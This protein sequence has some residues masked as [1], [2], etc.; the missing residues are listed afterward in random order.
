MTATLHLQGK[1]GVELLHDPLLNKGTAFTESERDALGLRGLLPPRVANQDQQLERVLENF[2][3]KTSDLEKYIYLI[4]LQERNEALFYRLVTQN[5]EEMMPI[6]YTPTVGLACQKYGHIF[7]RPR[8]LYITRKDRGRIRS[9]LQ[10]W[11]QYDVRIIVVTDGERILGLGDLGANGMGIPVGKLSLYTA[12]AGI[13]PAQTLPIMFDVGTNNPTLLADP[14]YLGLA[15]PRLRGPAYD[16][17]VE[18]F[19]TAVQDV[20]PR[21]CLQFEDFGNSNAFR[22]LHRY[23]NRTCTFNDDIQGTAG[24]TLSGAY[25]SLRL[26]GGKLAD[27]RFLFL[28]AGEAGIGIGDLIVEALK[29][30]SVAEAVARRQC[31][32]VDSKGLVVKSRTDLAEHKLPYAHEHAPVATFLEAVETLKP[33]MIVGVSGTPAGFTEEVV[34]AMGRINRRP[35]IFALS[36]PTSKAE[37]TA[38]QA[39]TWTEGRAIFASGSPFA[40]VTL[41]GIT[42]VPGQGNNSYIFPGVGLG[43]IASAATRVTDEMFFIAARTLASLVTENDLMLGR[44]YPDLKRI[45]EVSATIAVAVAENAFQRGLTAMLRPADL[46]AHIKGVMYDP[47]YTD[48]V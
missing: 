10:N 31:W 21:A 46:A 34:K 1:R 29:A 24:V 26:T 23:R 8:G 33:T 38:E 37:C 7:R 13:P 9:I 30:E 27:Q 43:V 6:I 32:F 12:C 16:E 47:H 20:F 22:L 36:N 40:P 19:V 5:L 45:R 17:L 3:R 41:N 35:V 48:Y 28:G 25:S 18:E 4:S 2:R 44:V 42:H 14:L 11:P 15:E 39:Y